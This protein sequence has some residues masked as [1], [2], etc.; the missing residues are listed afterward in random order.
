[1]Q[2]SFEELVTKHVY[3]FTA[4]NGVAYGDGWFIDLVGYAMNQNGSGAKLV[5]MYV[6]G[7][8]ADSTIDSDLYDPSMTYALRKLLLKRS[9]ERVSKWLWNKDEHDFR[10]LSEK[11]FLKIKQELMQAIKRTDIPREKIKIITRPPKR[12]FHWRKRD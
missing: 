3:T 6:F 2:K 11:E 5:L 9:C 4:T 1:M 8:T 10:R 7:I 12:W